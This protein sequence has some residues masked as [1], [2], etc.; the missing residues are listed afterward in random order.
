MPQNYQVMENC[1]TKSRLWENKQT[2]SRGDC[3]LIAII[4]L[5][6][7]F[8]LGDQAVMTPPYFGSEPV[9]IDIYM[10]DITDQT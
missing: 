6:P 7:Y 10:F 2:L 4:L 9:A 5:L 8:I 3:S 1:S